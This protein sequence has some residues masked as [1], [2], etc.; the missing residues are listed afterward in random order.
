MEYLLRLFE[1][2]AQEGRPLIVPL[3]PGTRGVIAKHGA[4]AELVLPPTN[5]LELVARVDGL[6]R[7]GNGLVDSPLGLRATILRYSAGM[8]WSIVEGF[9]VKTSGELWGF[10]E[11]IGGTKQ[12]EVGLH[13]AGVGTF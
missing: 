4:Y 3:A 12:W 9:R 10:S 6:H 13:V 5:W 11:D 8:V 1:F 7:R 2:E